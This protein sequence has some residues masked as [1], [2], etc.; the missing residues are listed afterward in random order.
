MA[1]L[2]SQLFIA[3][4]P[5]YCKITNFSLHLFV[6]FFGN[7]HNI[8]KLTSATSKKMT[9]NIIFVGVTPINYKK[10]HLPVRFVFVHACPNAQCYRLRR[11]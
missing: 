6:Y 8:G 4:I 1:A 5:I 3:M 11:T 9:T 10:V 7:N 2:V